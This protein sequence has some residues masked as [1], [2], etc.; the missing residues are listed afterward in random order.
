[1]AGILPF[2]LPVFIVC[3]ESTYR[4]PIGNNH[5]FN[6]FINL[7]ID[8]RASVILKF[9]NSFVGLDEY[10][11]EKIKPTPVANPGLFLW[12]KTLAEQ[13][14]ISANPE[15]EAATLANVFSGNQILPGS[16]PLAMAYAG[17]Q[18]G[19]FSQQLGDGRAHLLGEV[20]DQSGMRRDIQLKGS[21][22]SAF[23]R[24]GDGRCALGPAV[25]EFIMSE[26]MYALGVP[27]TRCLSVV[28]TGESVYRDSVLPGAVVTRVASSHLRVGTFEYF[29]ARRH[30]PA[31][32]TL[33]SYAIQRHFA[34]IDDEF[35][36]GDESPERYIALI[37]A[38]IEKQI[39]LISDWMR[40]G[41]IHG[42]MNTDNTAISG[43]TIDFGPCAMMGTYDPK[44][45]Y[46]SID[47]QG[48]YAFGNQPAIAQWNMA[49]FAECLLPLIDTDE[50]KAIEKVT[51]LIADFP[52][53][54]ETAFMGMM[55]KK[56]GLV[57][58]QQE[59]QPLLSGLLVALKQKR[60]DYTAT[61]DLLTKSLSSAGSAP[62][63][64]EGL[65]EWLPQWQARL[66]AQ[67]TE[68]GVSRAEAQ[69]LMRQQN[70]VV[71]PRN[72]H[73]EAVLKACEESG[74]ATSAEQFLQVLRSPYEQL[75][76]TAQ[77]M[78]PPDDGDAC[79]KTFCGT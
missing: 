31:L 70:P 39:E 35:G 19:H 69:A 41:F 32:K 76:E 8:G 42:V 47:A 64:M 43:E 55:A 49:R 71:I 59:D 10:F 24:G 48:R 20:I 34:A 36:S 68:R 6:V 37:D 74:D 58:F 3:S 75:P 79:Y 28:T 65:G 61:F 33:C 40:V 13:L 66:G 26:A 72:H 54:F 73:V 14:G 21:G 23:S 9:S 38:A 60:M 67:E 27:T 25:R 18:F 50:A 46:S 78:D 16:E 15:E 1:M 51:P 30:L 2:I 11:Y 5:C 44:T 57:E 56:L 77:Y 62:E 53:R 22:R 17:H 63:L 52:A 7:S 12:N 45:V 29:S 4:L